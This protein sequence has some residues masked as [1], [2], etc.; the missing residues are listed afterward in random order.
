MTRKKKDAPAPAAEANVLT[1]IAR[2]IIPPLQ[3]PG[4][5]QPMLQGTGTNRLTQVST[6]SDSA[7]IDEITG[8]ATLSKGTLTVFIEKYKTLTGGLRVSTHKLL[9]AC[10]IVLTAQNQFRGNA[11]LH[12]LVSIPL[13][14]YMVQC[15][16][17]MTKASKDKTRKRVREDL[18]TLYNTSI[19]WTEKTGGSNTRDY[20]KT[21]IITFQGI[22]SGNIFVRFS[23]EMADYLTHAY[24]MQYSMELFRL[25]E[26]NSSA[27][28]IG[29][30]ILSHHSMY[31]NQR[32]G[33]ASILSVRALLAAAP[34][35][36]SYE[37]VMASDRHL[38]RKIIVP[39]ENAMNALGNVITWEYANAK[40]AP[41][42]PE[43]LADF[44]YDVFI[45]SYVTFDV[46][47]DSG[48]PASLE[49]LPE[50]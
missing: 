28:Y 8:T 33:T 36:P 35:I 37:T 43:Q 29:K 4:R 12:T 3:S 5:F 18:E 11:P 14:D 19:E 49:P 45:R 15:N 39:F 17:P 50:E 7:N 24:L 30:K 23:E 46:R 44:S 27:Y 48:E 13:E 40:A 6:R 38:E 9:D 41:L 42:T 32:K 47:G 16:I 20:A 2:T 21:R 34:D 10:T 22:K 26:R 1:P 31:T 25:D